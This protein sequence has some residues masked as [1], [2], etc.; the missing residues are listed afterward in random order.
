MDG[1]GAAMEKI[2]RLSQEY[3]TV[4]VFVPYGSLSGP[5][6]AIAGG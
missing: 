3:A 5:S 6:T 1:D 2:G 4:L